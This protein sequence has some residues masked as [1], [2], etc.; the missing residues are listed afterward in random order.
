MAKRGPPK[1]AGGRPPLVLNF[2]EAKRAASIGCT[3]SEI[4]SLLG[5]S[6]RTWENRLAQDAILA[7]QI[8]QAAD[9]GRASLRRMQW[10]RAE[11]GSDMMLIW[12][13]KNLLDQT[14]DRSDQAVAQVVVNNNQVTI[15]SDPVIVSQDYRRIVDASDE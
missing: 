6:T 5:I 1:G 12:L 9:E 13:G 2:E 4:A 10:R 15:T 3:K 8:E 7:E 11:M 14:G